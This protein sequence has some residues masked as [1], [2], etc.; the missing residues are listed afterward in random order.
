MPTVLLTKLGPLGNI[1][2]FT[3]LCITMLS[4]YLQSPRCTEMIHLRHNIC[5]MFVFNIVVP[6][7]PTHLNKTKTLK[8]IKIYLMN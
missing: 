8:K 6:T 7:L 1:P 3:Y 4:K 5:I 2:E